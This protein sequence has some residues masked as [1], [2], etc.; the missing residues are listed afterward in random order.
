MGL[1]RFRRCH[2]SGSLDS[3]ASGPYIKPTDTAG[4]GR[5]GRMAQL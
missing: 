3:K 1:K 2:R 4:G 5:V